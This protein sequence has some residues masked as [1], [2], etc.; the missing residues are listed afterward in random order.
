MII[1]ISTGS[2]QR[3]PVLSSPKESGHTV[4]NGRVHLQASGTL[5]SRF[6][7]CIRSDLMP[8]H[9]MRLRVLPI[10]P[11]IV[12]NCSKYKHRVH[13]TG[14]GRITSRVAQSVVKSLGEAARNQG[15]F[16]IFNGYQYAGDPLYE[17]R[18]ESI[19]EEC[20]S[21]RACRSLQMHPPFDTGSLLAVE[22]HHFCLGESGR[23]Q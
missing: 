20:E 9:T 13:S 21:L 17:R 16:F 4:K 6:Q 18:S 11:I 3:L 22:K 15:L 8:R 2:V 5:G 10:L 1:Q 19:R 12:E 23:G 14:Q 7:G